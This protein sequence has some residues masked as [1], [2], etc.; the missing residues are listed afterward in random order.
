MESNNNNVIL[1]NDENIEKIIDTSTD[2]NSESSQKP[3]N[4]EKEYFNEK[5]NI[6]RNSSVIKEV[7]SE[8]L[9]E[10]MKVIYPL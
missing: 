4:T 5:L 7:Y 6:S 3:Y 8:N 2:S 10:E 1:E 9:D